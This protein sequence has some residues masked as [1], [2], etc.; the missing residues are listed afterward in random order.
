[1]FGDDSDEEEPVK[2]KSLEDYKENT[3]PMSDPLSD[4]NPD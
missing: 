2:R 3:D 4:S 1:M